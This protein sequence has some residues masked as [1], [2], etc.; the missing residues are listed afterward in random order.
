MHG[1]GCLVQLEVR[2][3]GVR[4]VDT[5]CILGR[6]ERGGFAYVFG[7]VV[8]GP[9]VDDVHIGGCRRRRA[10]CGASYSFH[11]FALRGDGAHV[12]AVGSHRIVDGDFLLFPLGIEGMVLRAVTHE[13]LV[14]CDVGRGVAIVGVT[15]ACVDE[16]KISGHVLMG[17]NLFYVADPALEVV[18]F[19]GGSRGDGCGLVNLDVLARRDFAA[20]VIV[21]PV[22]EG[23]GFLV[24]LGVDGLELHRVCV[25][26]VRVEAAR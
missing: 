18:A 1:D 11:R 25:G 17:I 26:A 2:V 5:I 13:V 21:V 3:V 8:A 6:N 7:S 4:L 23:Q 16:P 10:S 22:D 24:L 9:I 19:A 14:C 12:G 20:G 15:A